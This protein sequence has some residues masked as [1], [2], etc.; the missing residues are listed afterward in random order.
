MQNAQADAA[1]KV[2][3]SRGAKKWIV[4]LA[5]VNSAMGVA[6]DKRSWHPQ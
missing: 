5:N 3:H 4:L 1:V 2:K 6:A